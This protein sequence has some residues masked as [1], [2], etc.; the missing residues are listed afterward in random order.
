MILFLC[1]LQQASANESAFHPM[2]ELSCV[3]TVSTFPYTESFEGGLGPWTEQVS[4]NIWRHHSGSTPSSQT[5]PS[6]A[7]DGTFYAYVESSGSGS[8]NKTAILESPCFNLSTATQAQFSFHYHMYGSQ[9]GILR[10]EVSNNNG[11]SWTNIWSKSGDQ[12]NQWWQEAIDLSAFV[13]QT[14]KLRFHAT[15]GSSFRGDMAVDNVRL[16]TSTAPTYLNCNATINSFPYNESFEGG[17]GNW[18]IQSTGYDIW[19]RWSGSTPSGN[20]GPSSA[21]NGSYYLYTEASS[22]NNPNK[23]AILQGPCFDL[24]NAP[25]ATFSFKYHMNG[26]HIGTI[27]LEVSTNQGV[28]WTTAWAK[29]GSQSNSWLTAEVDLSSFTGGAIMLRFYSLTGSSYSGDI[30]IDN[31]NLSLVPLTVT[32]GCSQIINSFPYQ[33]SFEV[34]FGGWTEQV[35]NNIWQRRSGSTYSGSTGPSSAFDGIYYAYTEASSPN[36]PNKTAV[37]ESPCFDLSSATIASL[38][39]HYHM[40]GSAIGSIKLQVST[41]NGVGWTTIWSESGNKGNQ[42]LNTTVDLSNYT[43]QVVQLRFYSVTGNS[44]TGDIA[45]DNLVLDAPSGSVSGLLSGNVTFPFSSTCSDPAYQMCCPS[46]IAGGNVPNAYITVE[47]LDNGT[48]TNA[49]T[50]GSGTFSATTTNGKVKVSAA[51]NSSN[52]SNGLSTYD[53]SLVSQ[54][55]NGSRYIECPLRRIAADLDS[56]GDIDS[57]DLTLLNQLALGF[58]SSLP[59]APNWKFVPKIYAD[60]EDYHPDPVFVADFWNNNI[61]DNSGGQYPFNASIRLEGDLYNYLGS[62][63]WM[64]EINGFGFDANP[65][66]SSD[67]WGFYAVKTGDINGSA[68]YTS[69]SASP[70][71]Q[72]QGLTGEDAQNLSATLKNNEENTRIGGLN[73]ED[74]VEDSKKNK[75]YTVTFYATSKTPITAFQMGLLI[76]DECSQIRKIEAEKSDLAMAQSKNFGQLKKDFGGTYLKMMWQ[77][78]DKRNPKG[79]VFSERMALFSFDIRSTRSPEQISSTLLL[80]NTILDTEFYGPEGKVDEV[81]LEMIIE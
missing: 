68:S 11:A 27:R 67:Y 76:D 74:E 77:N 37:L 26:F 71:Q 38:A 52:W 54:H 34:S 44:Y 40:Y 50:N 23:T 57:D 33:E 53:L 48:S 55:I 66:C 69:F 12:D 58:I 49:F 46:P 2:D 80:D 21:A 14:V 28:S 60:P 4:S 19:D 56:D 64:T 47:N 8:P 7:Q 41:N 81:D 35:S 51:G 36:F 3:S 22:P 65:V 45:I 32:T 72:R 42:W 59:N 9:I 10:L 73:K 1:L 16:S 43:G 70:P 29:T 24:S 20:T 63:Q 61:T 15:T 30:A 31:L 62:K 79:K 75:K 5:G 18:S 25:A 13:G 6:S 78:E 39:F 17:M